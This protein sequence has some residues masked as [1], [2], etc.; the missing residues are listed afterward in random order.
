MCAV[1]QCAVMDNGDLTKIDGI[2]VCPT[3][4]VAVSHF[5][6][7]VQ[8][9]R[10]LYV[11]PYI[12]TRRPYRYCLDGDAFSKDHSLPTYRDCDGETFY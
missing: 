9:E 5:K 11:K 7:I 10:S 4:T 2:V 6:F 12:S 1:I 3:I 8:P